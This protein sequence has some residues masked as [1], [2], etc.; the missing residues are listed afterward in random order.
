MLSAVIKWARPRVATTIQQRPCDGF[1]GS[2]TSVLLGDLGL[3]FALGQTSRCAHGA[4]RRTL[5]KEGDT[6]PGR[7]RAVAL[8]E[9]SSPVVHPPNGATWDRFLGERENVPPDANLHQA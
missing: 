5:A 8:H 2:V 9:T 6:G 3:N 4:I 7:R 1:P